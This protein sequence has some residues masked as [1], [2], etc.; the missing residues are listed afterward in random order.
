[1]EENQD[2]DLLTDKQKRFIEQYCIHF[3]GA[4]AAREAG[5]SEDTAKVIAFE[6]LT[7]PYLKS[8]IDSR[9]RELTMS[10]DEATKRLTDMARG[11]IESFLVVDESGR[12][13]VDLSKEEAKENLGLIKK[14][15]QTKKEFADGAVIEITNKI[16]L[17]DQKDAIINIL[18]LHGKFVN[19]ID[20]T[21][22]GQKIGSLSN[23]TDEEL[24][25]LATLK[26]KS[27]ESSE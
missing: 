15:E 21:S 16:E 26:R 24:Q 27:I 20:M 5:Y 1:M 8:A 3:N 22:K 12:T 17:H 19:N 2:I 4:R 10:A 23:F 11:S 14:I 25:L 9:L 6:N 7:K 13:I 18:K